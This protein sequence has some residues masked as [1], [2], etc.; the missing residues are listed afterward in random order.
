MPGH[1][2]RHRHE[3]KRFAPPAPVDRARLPDEPGTQRR[4]AA[5]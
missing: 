5:Q 2:L 4:F 3:R 1:A